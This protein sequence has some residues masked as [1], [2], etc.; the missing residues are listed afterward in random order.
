MAKTKRIPVPAEVSIPAM[1]KP[2]NKKGLT[3]E[4]LNGIKVS[5]RS[6]SFGDRPKDSFNSL[7]DWTQFVF[8][9]ALSSKSNIIR[10]INN[11][12]IIDGQF[13]SFAKENGISI[14][15]LYRDSIISWKE[16]IIGS[17]ESYEKFFMQGVFLIKSG[18]IEFIHAALFHKGA[19]YEDEISFFVLLP[20]ENYE[21]YISLRNQFDDWVQ[22]TNRDNLFIRVIHGDD[23]P[24]TKEMS[25][26]DLFLP[27][28]L[29]TEIK[30]MVE[31]F[32]SSKDWYLQNK[33][34]WKR[35][36]ILYGT[37]GLGKTSL[38]KAIMSQYDFKPVSIAPGANTDALY[39]AFLY[40]EENSP[41]LLF[42]EDLDSML[43][44]TIDTSSF[45]NLMDGVSSKNGL[46]IIATANNIKALKSSITDRPSRFDR[47]FE[48]PLP[49]PEMIDIYLHKWFGSM[50]NEKKYKEI[51]KIAEREE[52]SYAYLKEL[53]ISAFYEALAGNRKLP[54]ERDIDAAMR[55]LIKDKNVLS[56]NRIKIDRYFGEKG[57]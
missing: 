3:K 26:D 32:L 27:V 40:A 13:T 7:M 50:M 23:I 9:E 49:T 42:F 19:S 33:I 22:K 39:E 48:F 51:I 17:D 29:K 10:L 44:R 35:G 21:G 20:E 6:F 18:D 41:S 34:P 24:Y 15:C 28:E 8:V 57:E 2:I 54:N 5:E 46:L 12:I 1:T 52:F 55:R 25:W 31:G 56:G 47:K 16:N 38:I 11:S 37:A 43:D 30:S 53:Y 45:L 36:A 4:L 14:E